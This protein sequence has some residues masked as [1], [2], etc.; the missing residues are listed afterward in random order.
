MLTLPVPYVLEK[1]YRG[2][3]ILSQEPVYTAPDHSG[4]KPEQ[5]EERLIKYRSVKTQALHTT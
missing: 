4:T 3:A 1:L 5:K 2:P